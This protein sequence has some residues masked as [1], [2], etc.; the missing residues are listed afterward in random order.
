MLVSCPVLLFLRQKAGNTYWDNF[1][2]RGH[3]LRP[4]PRPRPTAGAT[5]HS[6]T[7]FPQEEL[8]T[9]LDR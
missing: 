1:T 2:H 4:R 5:S 3:V 8:I 9:D 7:T 6:D